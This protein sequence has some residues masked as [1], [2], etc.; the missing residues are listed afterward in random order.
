M[1]V[2]IV[3][4]KM[5]LWN[6][7]QLSERAAIWAARNG[8]SGVSV[9]TL[10]KWKEAG[11]VPR[12]TV[13]ALGRGRGSAAGWDWR[14]YRRILKILL[15]RRQGIRRREAMRLALWLE[16]C[17]FDLSCVRDDL[18][19]TLQRTT[20]AL[21]RTLAT[22]TW[23]RMPG[24]PSS[25]A[26]HAISTHFTGTNRVDGFVREL[27]L[28]P[29]A[30]TL[31][32]TTIAWFISAGGERLANAMMGQLF[33]PDIPYVTESRVVTDTKLPAHLVDFM[34]GTQ[35]RP[36]FL[37]GA[38]ALPD[39]YDSPALLGARQASEQELLNLRAVLM[40][41]PELWTLTLTAVAHAVHA[42]PQVLGSFALVAGPM[43][44]LCESLAQKPFMQHPQSRL[45]ALVAL[46]SFDPLRADHA[47]GLLLAVRQ[48]I[49]DAR[50][51]LASERPGIGW[52]LLTGEGGA[53][54]NPK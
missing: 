47:E 1:N 28:P 10:L 39:E 4:K 38:L 48:L 5:T 11:L 54:P 31:I 43:A 52:L 17:E 18:I 14:V 32:R 20:R 50:G 40:S 34:V 30:E 25:A 41:L 15:L 51:A 49:E 12:P 24:A 19:L 29:A 13:R 26:A 35:S 21:N 22:E 27:E 42:S 23:P 2:V 6:K 3:S 9:A 37:S 16:G 36:S 8:L 46:L 33:L 7:E 44:D 45:G 53:A